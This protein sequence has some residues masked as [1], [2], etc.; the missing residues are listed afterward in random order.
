M[1]AVELLHRETLLLRA[2]IREFLAMGGR[3]AEMMI[4]HVEGTWQQLRESFDELEENL[5]PWPPITVLPTSENDDDG[6][7]ESFD[8][9]LNWNEDEPEIDLATEPHQEVHPPR[10]GPKW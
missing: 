3:S 1:I 10:I 6:E 8:E 4:D 5:A 9:S 7:E 2:E